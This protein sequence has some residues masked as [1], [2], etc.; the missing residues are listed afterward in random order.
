MELVCLD[1]ALG[2]LQ[3]Y[4]LA[5]CQSISGIQLWENGLNLATDTDLRY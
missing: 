3:V 4:R 1:F 2:L 5:G